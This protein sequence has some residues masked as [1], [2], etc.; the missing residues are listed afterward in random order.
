LLLE[1]L[2]EPLERKRQG[3]AVSR[4]RA[5]SGHLRGIDLAI[6][7]RFDPKALRVHDLEEDVLRLHHLTRDNSSGG[8]D[9]ADGRA[10]DFGLDAG[11][12]DDLPPAT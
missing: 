2:A 7:Q 12:T 5:G 1:G 9:A 11:L 10:Q 3:S 4:G 8:N 6:G